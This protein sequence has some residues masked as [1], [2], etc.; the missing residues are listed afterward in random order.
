MKILQ[1]FLKCSDNETLLLKS[2][3]QQ[4]KYFCCFGIFHIITNNNFKSKTVMQDCSFRV[5]YYKVIDPATLHCQA[6][7]TQTI[8]FEI[9]YS[10]LHFF[11]FGFK[12]K[13]N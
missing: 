11:Y 6:S 9:F 7:L 4:V 13:P 5:K 2:P 10:T 3:F 8:I 12:T 1:W